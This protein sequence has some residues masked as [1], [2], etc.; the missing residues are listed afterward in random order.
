MTTSWRQNLDMDENIPINNNKFILI[1]R[2]TPDPRGV[3]ADGGR[4]GVRSLTDLEQRPGGDPGAAEP[5]HQRGPDRGGRAGQGGVPRSARP[6]G[7][8]DQEGRVR[9]LQATRGTGR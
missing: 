5:A 7:L 4:E 3:Q 2:S 6:G 9:L 1:S 8:Q